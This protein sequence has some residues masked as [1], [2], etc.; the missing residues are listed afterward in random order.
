MSGLI[1]RDIITQIRIL[2]FQNCTKPLARRLAPG[3]FSITF[4][5]KVAVFEYML[6]C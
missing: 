6:Y 3:T 5:K 4:S 2:F 1:Y